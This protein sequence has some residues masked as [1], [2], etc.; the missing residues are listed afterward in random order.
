MPELQVISRAVDLIMILNHIN[1]VG[2]P[3]MYD[4]TKRAEPGTLPAVRR[5]WLALAEPAGML[6]LYTTGALRAG[7]ISSV[8]AES[9]H[10]TTVAN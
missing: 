1:H 2:E 6:S 10:G 4:A 9:P 3:T 5:S 8:S 7:A